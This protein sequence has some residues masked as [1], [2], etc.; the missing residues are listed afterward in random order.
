MT[1]YWRNPRTGLIEGVTEEGQVTTVQKSMD[2]PFDATTKAGFTEVV[3]PD[4][5][6]YW[7]QEGV[8]IKEVRSW[9]YNPMLG[10]AVASE[11]AA[12]A[13]LS[14]MH[15]KFDWAPPYAIMARWM[16]RVP[17]FKEMVEQALKDRAVVHFEEIIETADEVYKAMK[18]DP[19]AMVAAGKLKIDARKFLAEKGDTDKFGAKQ[20]ASGEVNVQ[21]VIDTGIRREIKDVTPAVKE[22]KNDNV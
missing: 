17:E 8:D 12:G 21:I 18:D 11:I 14:T 22:L 6:I 4:G 3:R 15:K 16:Q 20:K 1:T 5:S 9:A 19:D 13:S 2:Q 10:G 7:I